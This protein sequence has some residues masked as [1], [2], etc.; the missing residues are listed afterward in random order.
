M[1]DVIAVASILAFFTVAAQLVRA[2]GRI[3]AASVDIEP[4]EVGAE[5]GPGSRA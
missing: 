5:D 4:G 1:S 2:C 3:M